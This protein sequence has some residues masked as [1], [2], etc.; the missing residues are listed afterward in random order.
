M[1]QKV[2]SYDKYVDLFMFTGVVIVLMMAPDFLFN[3]R[4]GFE[5]KNWQHRYYFYVFEVI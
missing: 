1:A 5:H 4:D 3:V 2:S